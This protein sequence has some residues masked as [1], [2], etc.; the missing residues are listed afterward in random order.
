[1]KYAFPRQREAYVYKK[2]FLGPEALNLSVDLIKLKR[3]KKL[4]LASSRDNMDLTS[5][6]GNLAEYPVP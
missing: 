6:I 3:L 2:Q 5:E 4:K 1:M